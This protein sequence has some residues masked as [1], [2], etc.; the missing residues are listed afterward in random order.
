MGSQVVRAS[1]DAGGP[2]GRR[3]N[4]AASRLKRYPP[5]MGPVVRVLQ[6]FAPAD[7]DAIT[8]LARA[9]EDVDG[10][11]PL[12]DDDWTGLHTA[13][14]GRDRGLAVEDSDGRLDAYAHLA[15]HHPGEWSVSLVTRPGAADVRLALLAH[16]VDVVA[17]AGG[18][19]LT[20]WVRGATDDD[21]VLAATAGL[22]PERELRQLRVPLPLD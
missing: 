10:V 22:R 8:S 15:H 18:G 7:V 4:T 6:Q 16:A 1:P 13:A 3:G 21:Q 14:E 20:A 17:D 9:V 11:S 5:L 2:D 19:H 12:D